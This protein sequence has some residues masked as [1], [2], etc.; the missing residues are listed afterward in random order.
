M[1]ASEAELL[2]NLSIISIRFAVKAC[3]VSGKRKAFSTNP[4]AHDFRTIK[5]LNII[6]E[7]T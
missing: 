1:W 2:G 6:E 7:E 4:H 3:G 5:S